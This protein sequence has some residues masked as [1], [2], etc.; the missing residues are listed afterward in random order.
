MT[1]SNA[2][3]QRLGYLALNVSDLEK[4]ARFYEDVV[5]LQRTETRG[6][7]V[8]FRCS[9]RHHDIVLHIVCATDIARVSTNIGQR[10]NHEVNDIESVAPNVQDQPCSGVFG[11]VAPCCTIATRSRLAWTA[12]RV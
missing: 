6:N 11:V 4:S 5:G 3:Y 2:R 7:H 8:L 12:Q 1:R 9:D 10:A